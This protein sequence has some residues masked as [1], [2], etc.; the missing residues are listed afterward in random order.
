MK[1]N[2][3][4]KERESWETRWITIE[5]REKKNLQCGLRGGLMYGNAF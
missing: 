3:I 4:V 1:Q 2:K 5:E